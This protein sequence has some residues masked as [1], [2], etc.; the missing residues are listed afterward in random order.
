MDN[1][2]NNNE[3]YNNEVYNNE[4]ERLMDIFKEKMNTHPE[5]SSIWY[6][7]L[8]NHNEKIKVIVEQGK[9]VI[10]NMDKISDISIQSVI[11][12]ILIETNRL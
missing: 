6:N 4:I 1:A 10:D 9:Y 11:L 2:I 8:K 12:S 5:L 7:Y 3:V